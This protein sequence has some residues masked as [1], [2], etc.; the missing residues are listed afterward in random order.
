MPF[1]IFE[2]MKVVLDTDDLL[3]IIARAAIYNENL[4]RD[5][6]LAAGA[7]L[8]IYTLSYAFYNAFLHPAAHIPGPFWGRFCDIHQIWAYLKVGD[9]VEIDLELKRRYGPVV[10][11]GPNAVACFGA[12][13]C[14]RPGWGCGVD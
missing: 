6:F 13:V 10:R 12:D 1:H 9:V 14:F 2:T 7:F 5:L 11:K 8:V 4:I 3:A